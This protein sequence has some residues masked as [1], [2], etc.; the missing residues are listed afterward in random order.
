MKIQTRAA[1]LIILLHTILLG[2]CSTSPKVSY[3][4]LNTSIPVK[5]RASSTESIQITSISIPEMLQRPHLVV[6]TSANRVEVLE[7]HRWA[8]TLKTEIPRIIAENMSLELKPTRVSPYPESAGVDS[9]IRIDLDFRR[10]EISLNDGVTV[11]L[12]WTIMKSDGEVLKTGH[13]LATEKSE[14]KEYDTLVAAISRAL[15]T[16][17]HELTE[18]VADINTK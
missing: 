10:F 9:R 5:A 13:S 16:V 7:F 18:S 12:F 3:Y 6:R 17:S 11:D 4:T 14:S 2:A 15:A 8:E 1:G